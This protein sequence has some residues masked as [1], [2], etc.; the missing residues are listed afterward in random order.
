MTILPVND[1]ATESEFLQVPLHI[2][3]NDASWIQPLEKDIRQVFD[4]N[5]NKCFRFGT[6]QRWILKNSEGQLIGRIAAFIYKKYKNKGDAFKVGG[7]GFFECVNQQEAADLLFDNARYW[8]MNQGVQA[9]D[10]PINFGERDKWWGLLVEGF[11]EP[12]Y[13]MNYNPPY[14]KSLFE[15][16]GFKPFYDQICMG[17]DLRK[18]LS[19]RI[20]QRHALVANDSDFSARHIQKNDLKTYASHFAEVYNKAWAGHGG[21]K[22]M[23]ERTVITM[24]KSMKPIID[25]K[26]SWFVYYKNETKGPKLFF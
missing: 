13:G 14:Y 8:L 4:P 9:M 3:R 25:E 23:E 7:I 1:S 12:L 19:D 2:Y 24:F 5:K 26:I 18:Q 21:L 20:H 22:Q 10:G 6:A 11:H 16:Y 17:M 15:Q